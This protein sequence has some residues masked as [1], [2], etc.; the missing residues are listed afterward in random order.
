LSIEVKILH[1]MPLRIPPI[2]A[3]LALDSFARLGS[4][5]LAAEE[6]GVTRS[7]VSHRLALLED[8]V[9]FSVLK[10][11]GKGVALTARGARYAV[12]VGKALL[13]LVG[14]HHEGEAP[15][16]EGV[17]RVSSTAGFASM[18]LCN[19]LGSF[20]AEH[21]NLRLDI[22]T[23]HELDATPHG[24]IDVSVVFGGGNWPGYEVR[25][26]YDV[27]FLPVCSPA[28]L[29]MKGGL[30][31]P[32]DVLR[33]P[34]LHLRHM[35]DWRYWLMLNGLQLPRGT[36]GIIFSDMMLVQTAAIAA[37]GVM[38]GDEVTCAGALAAGLLVSPFSTTIKSTDG[39]Y[40]LSDRRKRP[41]PA[42]IAFT[43]WLDA[44]ITR[45]GADLKSGRFQ[46]N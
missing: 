28:L 24:D 6:L 35:D 40:L 37:Q 15:P 44:L 29:N 41:N 14:A 38:M 5:T 7:A 46:P 1:I 42:V 11:A 18:W 25:H 16:I 27:E 19:H 20:C 3:L 13:G 10:R 39:Y 4:V 30:N 32:A 34:L 45:V 36:P 33:Y 31:A 2:H 9:G 43:R 8:V 22:V 23:R 17:L 12:D 21:P 26:L